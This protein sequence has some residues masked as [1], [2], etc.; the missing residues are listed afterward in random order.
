MW[1]EVS[2]PEKSVVEEATGETTNSLL[3]MAVGAAVGGA[4][5][6]VVKA[7]LG[8]SLEL[9]LI[10]VGVVIAYTIGKSN[11]K[12]RKAGHGAALF[13]VGALA[14]NYIAP[15]IAKMLPGGETASSGTSDEFVMEFA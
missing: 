6:L 4:V 5:A 9:A 15:H 7:Y 11:P 13:G 3:W 1:L 12:V 10:L 2:M 14:F 8:I